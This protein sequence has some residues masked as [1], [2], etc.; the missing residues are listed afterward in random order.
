MHSSLYDCIKYELHLVLYVH[1]SVLLITN[2]MVTSTEANEVVQ[3][4][5]KIAAYK[6]SNVRSVIPS[7]LIYIIIIIQHQRHFAILQIHIRSRSFRLLHAR[8]T[9]SLRCTT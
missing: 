3:R 6:L 2:Y 7:S 1:T 9:H 4:I 5:S 8:V